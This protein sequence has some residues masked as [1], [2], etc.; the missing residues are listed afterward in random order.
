MPPGLLLGVSQ[1]LTWSTT[2]IAGSALATGHL[3][4]V[5][6]LRPQPFYL[7]RLCRRWSLPCA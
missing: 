2:V 5:Y 1:G 3:A 7:V 6:G 4:A